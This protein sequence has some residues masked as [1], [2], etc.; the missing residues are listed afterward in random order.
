[1]L[2][3]IKVLGGLSEKLSEM[4]Q[5]YQKRVVQ[6]SLAEEEKDGKRFEIW[7][8]LI[9]AIMAASLAIVDL[10]AGKYGD[11]EM[12]AVN[13]KASAYQWYQAKAV[14]QSLVEGRRDLLKSLT[15]SGSI[16]ADHQSAID[17][18]IVEADEE[19]SRYGKEKK[20]ILLGSKE[21]GRDNWIQEVD[22]ELGKVVGATVWSKQAEGL[23]DAGDQ[24]DVAILFLQMCLVMGAIALILQNPKSRYFFM[25]LMI[26]MGIGGSIL[27]YKAYLA[28]VLISGA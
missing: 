4:T 13:E 17:R 26:V 7:C 27:G 22:G 21:V 24:F 2:R 8:G 1:M 20:E 10:Y 25:A 3:S 11:D 6:E 15:A 23:S 19:I 12:I 16:D 28:A 14:R 9:L 5:A 18:L